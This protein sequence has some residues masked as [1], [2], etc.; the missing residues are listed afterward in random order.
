MFTQ[1]LEYQLDDRLQVYRVKV[2]D[3]V[4]SL[5][6]FKLSVEDSIKDI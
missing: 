5:T 2:V 4:K 6:K 1:M 3:R